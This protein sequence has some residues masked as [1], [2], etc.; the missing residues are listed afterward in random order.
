MAEDY[1]SAV[2]SVIS[3]CKDAEQG[4]DGAAKAVKN[5]SLKSLFQQYSAQRAGFV[6]ELQDAVR[7]LGAKAEDPA[8]VAGV[9]HSGWMALKGALTG[10]SEHQI[11]EETERGEDLSLS[12]YREALSKGVPEPLRSIVQRQYEKVQQAHQRI[13][14][15][16]DESAVRS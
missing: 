6:T 15:L 7:G 16:R 5:P 8:G 12:T 1:I 3:I 9:L 11:L 2:N 13:R 14:A 10:H 4:F